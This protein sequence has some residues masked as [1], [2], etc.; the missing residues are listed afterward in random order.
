MTTTITLKESIKLYDQLDLGV[1]GILHVTIEHDT[2]VIK[3]DYDSLVDGKCGIVQVRHYAAMPYEMAEENMRLFAREVMPELKKHV[4]LE[5]Q[6]IAR[7][8]TGSTADAEAF[9][10]PPS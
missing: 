3:Y 2:A 5:D 1:D 8:G 10:L 7:A 4:S 6:L 9:R